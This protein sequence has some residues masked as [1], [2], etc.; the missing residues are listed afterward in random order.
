MT[1]LKNFSTSETSMEYIYVIQADRFLKDGVTHKRTI[2]W[3][4]TL[5]DAINSLVNNSDVIAE[6]AEGVPFYPY[7]LIEEVPKGIY[8]CMHEPRVWFYKW[9]TADGKNQYV[10][11]TRPK[12]LDGIAG[13]TMG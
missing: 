4:C 2:G 9:G 8:P 12:V 6:V 1:R 7:A 11:S 10:P 5:G 3:E 13:L